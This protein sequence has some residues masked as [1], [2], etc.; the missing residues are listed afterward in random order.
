MNRLGLDYLTLPGVAPDTFVRLAAEAGCGNV[1]LMPALPEFMQA[2]GPFWS[3]IDDAALRSATRK[4][5]ADTGVSLALLDGFALFPGSTRDDHRR[6]L[7]LAADLG[8]RRLNTVSFLDWPRTLD[9]TAWMVALAADYGMTVTIE[10]CPGL[11][12]GTLAQALELIAYVGQPNF[13]L[14]IDTMHVARTG[15]AGDLAA[16]D[17]G[18]IDYVQISDA[19]LAMPSREAYMEEALHE[20]MIPGT[21]ELPLVEMLRAVPDTV[22]VSAEVPLRSLAEAGVGDLERVRLIVAGIDRVLAAAAR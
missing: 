18:L 11:T 5:L 10:P 2:S 12:A 3:L 9:D 21:G 14:L 20:R 4:A 6:T 22:V 19:P 16:L 17:P 8:T 15:G 7:D 13:K 1:A